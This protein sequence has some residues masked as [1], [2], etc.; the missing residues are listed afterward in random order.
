MLLATFLLLFV[1]S[2]SRSAVWC[3]NI[4]AE[5]FNS[6]FD[7]SEAVSKILEDN[8]LFKSQ[9]KVMADE[10]EHYKSRVK[11]LE[12]DLASTNRE[13]ISTK[14]NA[15]N[16]NNRV[17][18][19]ERELLITKEISKTRAEIQK[20]D[21]VSLSVSDRIQISEQNSSDNGYAKDSV[22]QESNLPNKSDTSKDI[23]RLLVRDNFPP[24]V[25]FSSTMDSHKENL[26][27]GQTVL[28]EHVITN[29][30][31]GLDPN[32][33]IFKAPITGVYH[34]D[35]IIMSHLGEDM[36]TEIVKNGNGLV[37]LYSG[38]GDTWGVGMQAIVIQMNAGD[39][40]W[41]RVYNNRGVNDG[42]I[43]VFGEFWSS[44]SGFLLQ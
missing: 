4:N 37:R 30:G 15:K 3:F 21:S 28:F 38:N 7:I 6:P 34:F 19:L 32:T 17:K 12:S 41:V 14:Q 1:V 9:L 13:L 33:S 11:V 24:V 42:N 29:I 43:R 8:Q 25:A 40:V 39:D 31:N 16:T 27:I 36:E 18:V 23:K 2:L 22:F 20:F 44:F 26:G 35:V 5:L 10:M